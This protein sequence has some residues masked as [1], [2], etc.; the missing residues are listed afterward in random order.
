MSF[1]LFCNLSPSVTFTD[2]MTRSVGSFKSHIKDCVLCRLSSKYHRSIGKVCDFCYSNTS[3]SCLVVPTVYEA[4]TC[5]NHLVLPLKKMTLY[6]KKILWAASTGVKHQ[7][8]YCF[9]NL[10]SVHAHVCTYTFY[11]K[12]DHRTV[13]QVKTSP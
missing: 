4:T 7:V 2:S 1:L 13:W 12:N 5:F 9:K 11:C 6:L 3:L 10:M 8:T